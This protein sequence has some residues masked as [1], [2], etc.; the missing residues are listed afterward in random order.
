MTEKDADTIVADIVTAD[1][2]LV[3]RFEF[4]RATGRM[5]HVD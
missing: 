3:W 4:D 1:D 5:S 2:S